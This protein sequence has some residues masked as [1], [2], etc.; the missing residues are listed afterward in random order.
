MLSGIADNNTRRI[1]GKL[2]IIWDSGSVLSHYRAD[3]VTVSSFGMQINKKQNTEITT[4]KLKINPFLSP[5]VEDFW[6]AIRGWKSR[7]G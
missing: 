5:Q 7:T 4:Y 6:V 3:R 2:N 1:E